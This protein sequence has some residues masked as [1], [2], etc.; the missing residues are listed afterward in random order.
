[1]DRPLFDLPAPAR[2][3]VV[4]SLA[5]AIGRQP[6]VVFAFLHG[7]FTHGGPFHDVDVA[8]FLDVPAG[9]VTERTPDLTDRLTRDVGY[10]VDV[11]AVNDAPLAF[12]F[13]SLQGTLLVV[14][15]EERMADFMERVGRL[16]LDIAPVL[17]RAT[18]E[19]F[20]R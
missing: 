8:V 10:P 14:H 5:D 19:A 7:S 20:A 15:D 11:R 9:R 4:R 1:V 16:Y 2:D 18:R 13:R 6:A 17:R 12:Q 3:A